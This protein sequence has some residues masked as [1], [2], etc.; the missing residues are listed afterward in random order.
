M[1]T[2]NYV[3]LAICVYKGQMMDW[4]NP[5]HEAKPMKGKV[6]CVLTADLFFFLYW[7]YNTTGYVL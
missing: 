2:C 1:L 4:F 3:I 7:V 6:S 5:K